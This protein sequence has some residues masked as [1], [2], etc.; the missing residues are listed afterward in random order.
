MPPPPTNSS[1]Q[2]A[3]GETIDFRVLVDRPIVEI[4]VN[5]GRASFISAD[6]NFSTAHT[7]IRLFNNGPI[8]V[9]ATNVSAFS[10]GCGWTKTKPIPK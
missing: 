4:F 10:M 6:Q 1:L 5:Q 7:E 9:T 2:V 3:A 8:A